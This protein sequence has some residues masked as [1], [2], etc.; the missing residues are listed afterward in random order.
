MASS[1]PSP[2]L[3]QILEQRLSQLLVELEGLFDEHL[4]AQLEQRMS[5]AVEQA[6]TESRDQA[7]LELADM[8][9]Q[10]ARRIRQ[11][12]DVADLT[13]TLLDASAPFSTGA[14]VFL[15]G[16]AMARGERMR[17]VPEDRARAF[18]GLEIP[19]SSAAALGEAAESADPV[20]TVTAPSEISAEL[21]VFA[22]HSEDARAFIYPLV[23]RGR[24]MALLYVWG[25]VVGSALELLTQ[26]AAAV[27]TI[28]PAPAELVSIAPSQ[29]AAAPTAWEKLS[30]VEQQLHLRAQRFARVQVAEMRLFET[31]AVQAGRADRDLYSALR[32]RIDTARDAFRRTFFVS[33]PSM[34]DYLHLELV[35]TLAHDDPEALG[36]DYPGPMV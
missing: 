15:V 10:G 33:S 12:V 25:E 5:P 19:F 9:N 24:T 31:D 16:N 22:G 17:G 36:S 23:V 4:T 20:A 27:W 11:S 30:P 1:A 32:A 34:V 8:L 21:G 2:S 6:A 18:R 7:R 13:A 35:R 26:L 28:M 14:A 29:T 3:R